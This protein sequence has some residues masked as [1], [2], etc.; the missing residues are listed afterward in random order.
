MRLVKRREGFKLLQLRQ[1]I[2]I[3]HHR[4]GKLGTTMHDPVTDGLEIKVGIG[5]P[6]TVNGRLHRA[7][8]GCQVTL[9]GRQRRPIGLLL[10][11]NA[12][13]ADPVGKACGDNLIAI[14]RKQRNL[15]G[16]RSGIQGEHSLCHAVD[17]AK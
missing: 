6:K 5:E 13:G 7:A 16:G 3:H 9:R 1:H 17:P 10:F 2:I 8:M 15:E 14:G 12:V 4:L 11:D